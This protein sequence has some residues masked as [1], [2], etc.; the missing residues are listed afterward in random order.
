MHTEVKKSMVFTMGMQKMQE[1]FSA[2]LLVMILFLNRPGALRVCAYLRDS[3]E[4]FPGLSTL[5]SENVQ[6]NVLI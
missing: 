4:F 6:K 3:T 5:T 2:T 1:Q